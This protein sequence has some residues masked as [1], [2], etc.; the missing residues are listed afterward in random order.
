[1]KKTITLFAILAN[2][3]CLAAQKV[4]LDRFSFYAKSR[5][6]PSNPLDSTYLTYK[7]K[8]AAP[9]K[10]S[11]AMGS[12]PIAD[13]IV[14]QGY[15]INWEKPDVLIEVFMSE[16]DIESSKVE[17]TVSVTKDKN[18]KEIKTTKYFYKILYRMSGN[19]E[20]AKRTGQPIRSGF[21]IMNGETTSW[22]TDSYDTYS[23]AYNAYYNNRYEIIN[24][25][26]RGKVE[27]GISNLNRTIN[28]EIGY[29]ENTDYFHLWLVDNKKHPESEVMKKMW[30]KLKPEITK[31]TFNELPVSS[32]TSILNAIKYF[33]SLSIKYP[34]KE[35][36]SHK[37]IRYASFYNKALLYYTINQPEKAL[38]EI[39]ALI[40]NGYDIKDADWLQQRCNNLIV[41][42]V[43]NKTNTRYFAP[44]N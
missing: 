43:K 28:Q 30:V 10:V 13:R 39:K 42:F 2:L 24:K 40:D 25:L 18:G 20:W 17:E 38:I 22:S 31:I 5:G 4:D 23:E 41:Q 36:K 29:P 6:L 12:T 8:V 3:I 14:L 33:D 1:M 15:Q 32:V 16:F 44:R 27:E 21:S 37:K 7:V 9:Y 34:E 35:E 11:S 26:I 19:A